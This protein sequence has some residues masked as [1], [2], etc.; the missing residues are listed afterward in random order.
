MYFHV[1][2][3]VFYNILL[4]TQTLVNVSIASFCRQYLLPRR[5]MGGHGGRANRIE[6]LV[7]MFL[8][9]LCHGV[10]LSAR[11]TGTDRQSPPPL[12]KS[13]HTINI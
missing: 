4:F 5:D 8:K 11:I 2:R 7:N 13:S 3:V 6:K 12:Q 1:K 10:W 9:M